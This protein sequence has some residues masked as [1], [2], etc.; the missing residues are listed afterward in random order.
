MSASDFEPGAF[1]HCRSCGAPLR[2]LLTPKGKRMP[3]DATT[4]EPGETHFDHRK[5]KSHFATC[6]QADMWRKP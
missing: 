1:S 4:V 6:G 3:T 5:H 2:W